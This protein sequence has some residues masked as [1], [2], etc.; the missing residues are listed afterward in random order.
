MWEI[1]AKYL[2]PKAL[3]SCPKFNKSPNLVTLAVGRYS[4]SDVQFA[5]SISLYLSLS[6][7]H[8]LNIFF[9][10][11]HNSHCINTH[12]L[13]LLMAH[14]VPLFHI[15]LVFWRERL[16]LTMGRIWTAE[17][18]SGQRPHNQLSQL[19]YLV[20]SFLLA[21]FLSLSQTYIRTFTI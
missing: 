15:F 16:K 7:S 20:A 6:I 17:C 10:W 4:H 2:L 13:S 8:V 21:L 3:K 14:F 1:W 11:F 5:A 18:W 19:S 9:C 12:P